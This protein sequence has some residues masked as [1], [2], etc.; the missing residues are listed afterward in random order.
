MIQDSNNR[1]L[2]LY[3]YENTSIRSQFLFHDV[4]WIEFC[5]SK[6]PQKSDTLQSTS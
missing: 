1:Y 2:E 3:F 6:Y 5:Y 4:N